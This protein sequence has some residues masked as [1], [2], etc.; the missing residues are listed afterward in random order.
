MKIAF[1]LLICTVTVLFASAPI[2]ANAA[3][4]VVS[5]NGLA[6]NAMMPAEMGASTPD[7]NKVSCGGTDKAAGLSWANPPDKTQSYALLEVD[8]D[9]RAGLGVNHWVVYNIPVSAT[10]INT[11]EIAAGKYTP[12][13]ATGDVVGYRAPCPP[14][15]GG[16]HHYIFTLFALD[17]PPALPAGLD[18]DGAVAAM[19][20]HVLGATTTILRFQR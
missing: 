8:P 5:S 19:K 7:A 3:A 2:A 9:G 15:G 18:H 14:V 13:K 6:D 10:G 12:G 17:A 16:P 20:G 1:R 4:F 11:A